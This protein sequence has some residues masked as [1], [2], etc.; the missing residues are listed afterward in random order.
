VDR[1]WGFRLP[2][3]C[4]C[5]TKA[6]LL[7]NYD[8]RIVAVADV[9]E[10]RGALLAHPA[11]SPSITGDDHPSS[12]HVAARR[13][14]IPVGIGSIY[15]EPTPDGNPTATWKLHG[16]AVDHGHR[17]MG[18]GALVVE[19]CLEHAAA[20]GANVVWCTAPAGAFGFFERCGFR[21]TGDP[22]DHRGGPQY[23]LFA[24]IGPLRRS[25]SI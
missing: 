21:R 16:V 24:E 5:L 9:L 14:E 12:C 22:V 8:I 15:S 19:R 23:K 4:L 13:N 10:L 17:G 25:W 20:H 11:G 7:S 18:V 1:D 6:S 3:S 2:V